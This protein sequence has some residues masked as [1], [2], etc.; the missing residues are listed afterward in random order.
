MST[1]PERR[2]RSQQARF[3]QRR[4]DSDNQYSG[5][6]TIQA[7]RAH[8]DTTIGSDTSKWTQ[9]RDGWDGQAEAAFIDSVLSAQ[10]RYG[11]SPTSGVRKRVN[12]WIAYRQS[13]QADFVR[14]DDLTELAKWTSTPDAWR[15]ANDILDNRQTLRGRGTNRPLKALGIAQAAQEFVDIGITSVFSQPT[16][17]ERLTR[18]PKKH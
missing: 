7:L 13:L 11:N 4:L 2:P 6:V 10:A 5:L 15:L 1:S 14:V 17:Q 16:I 8:I 3:P 18:A 12:N 9:W